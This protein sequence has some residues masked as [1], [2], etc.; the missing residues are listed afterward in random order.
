MAGTWKTLAAIVPLVLVQD[1]GRAR[2]DERPGFPLEVGE[3]APDIGLSEWL[4]EDQADGVKKIIKKV[5]GVGD[6][7]LGDLGDLDD[8]LGFGSTRGQTAK[9]HGHALIVHTFDWDDPASGIELVALVVDL[10]SANQARELAAIGIASPID[11]KIG[12]DLALRRGIEHP[13]AL[14]DLLGSGSP[15]VAGA[16]NGLTYAFLIGPSGELVWRGNPMKKEAGFLEAVR[17]ALA[18]HPLPRVEWPLHDELD[19]ALA[20]YYPGELSR[21]ESAA[22]KTESGAKPGLAAD[23][24]YLQKRIGL[25]AIELLHDLR[26]AV[27]KRRVDDFVVLRHFGR[28]A[29][30]RGEIAKEIGR[31]EK[32]AL[33][34]TNFQNRMRDNEKWLDL[35]EDRPALFPARKSRT[36]NKLAKKLEKFLRSTSN[37]LRVTRTAQE[38][39]DRYRVAD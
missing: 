13:V 6:V 37:S 18:R 22:A 24:D 10:V 5:G 20:G 8:L 34:V 4:G 39:L 7:D 17:D 27:S 11:E 26:E 28:I 32:E 29:F 1:P 9:H 21:A 35:Q 14:T 31:L 23:A 2:D 19:P 25:A 30:P 33:K 16:V 12:A 38:L 3:P 36:G 15:Y